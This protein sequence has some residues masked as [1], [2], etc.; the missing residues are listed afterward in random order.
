MSNYNEIEYKNQLEKL[1]NKCDKKL[2]VHESIMYIENRDGSFSWSKG[3]NGRTIDSYMNI[4]SITKLFTT[5]CILNLCEQGKLNLDDKLSKYFT[6]DVLSGIHIYKGKDYS[7][8]LTVRNLLF[9]N[10]GIPDVYAVEHNRLNKCIQKKGFP[11]VPFEEYVRIARDS[12]K[13]FAP[14]TPGKAHYSDIHFEMLALIIRQL[15]NSTLHEA[16]DKYVYKPLGLTKT[17]HVETDYDVSVPYY[18]KNECYEATGLLK[19]IPGCGG[20]VSTAREVMKFLKAF[21]TGELFDKKVFDKLAIPAG[22]QYCPTLGQYC[23]GYVRI[24]ISGGGNLWRYP[25]ELIG[26]MGGLGAYA[27]YYPQY[28]IFMVGDMNQF[29]RQDLVFTIP[30]GIAGLT[31]KYMK[32]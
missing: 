21:F 6:D 2:F 4:A 14:G 32:K 8:E 22:I 11:Y 23:G 9:Q 30:V 27:Y 13:R 17:H 15:E 1:F 31:V 29:A 26:H 12:K 20:L 10:T 25:G 7:Y 3:S 16:F 24:N 19:S 5:T 18:Y 28:D